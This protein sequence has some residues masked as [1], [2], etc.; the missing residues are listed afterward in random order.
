VLCSAGAVGVATMGFYWVYCSL[1]TGR[2]WFGNICGDAEASG[3]LST[4]L[5]VCNQLL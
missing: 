2:A 3:S 4:N 5:Q 1:P